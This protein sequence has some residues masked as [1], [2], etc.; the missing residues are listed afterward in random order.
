MTSTTF[1]ASEVDEFMRWQHDDSYELDALLARLRGERE[2]SEQMRAGTAL[3]KALEDLTDYSRD[4]ETL[5]ALGYTFNMIADVE[6]QPA[7]IREV[8][9]SATYPLNKDGS[10]TITITGRVDAIDGLRVD[11]HKS[12]ARYEPEHY[13]DGWQ[14]RFYLDIFGA[15]LF[16]WN[17]FEIAMTDDPFVWDV[18]AA[19]RLEQRRYPE[20]HADCARVAQELAEFAA[21]HMPERLP[22][23]T[24][25]E[26]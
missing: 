2:P 11:D 22:S 21:K 16:R 20:L 18:R 23:M 4:Y 3:H 9:A 26:A 15:D 17:I 10:A 19:H 5:S 7:P 25:Y 13:L 1:R 6:L 8:R 14:W 12:T 24:A